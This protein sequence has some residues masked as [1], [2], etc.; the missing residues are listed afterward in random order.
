MASD[1]HEYGHDHG[2]DHVYQEGEVAPGGITIENTLNKDD[3][4]LPFGYYNPETEGKLTWI[5]N[6]GEASE[7]DVPIIAVFSMDLGE[8]T[9][10]E[11]RVLKDIE[12][13]KYC[14]D[15]LIAAGWKK[16]IPPKIQFTVG[17]QDRPLN[18][19]QRRHLSK[20][21]TEIRNNEKI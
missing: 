19:Q 14:R 2:S 6:Y 5:C 8:S 17:G 10:R 9:D 18:R 13:A 21:I 15:E 11:I 3:N 4:A 12:E 20:K 16:I 1:D 7:G